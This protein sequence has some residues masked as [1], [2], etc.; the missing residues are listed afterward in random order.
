MG[1]FL[2]CGIAKSIFVEKASYTK[3]EI[4]KKLAKSIDLNIYKEPKENEEYLFLDLKE[5]IIEKYAVKFIEE[6]LE[7]AKEN[8]N[9][10]YNTSN[11]EELENKKYDEL[12]QIADRKEYE[13]FQLLEGD[14]ADDLTIIAD[15]IIFLLDGKVIM[16]CYNVMFRYFRN[17][18]IRNSTNPIKTATVIS[19]VG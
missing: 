5:N 3:E 16:E 1:Q 17:Q 7:I 18:I 14:L 4:L 12:M 11:I 13:S 15:I 9:K 19:I 6:Q 8:S 2:S 10:L